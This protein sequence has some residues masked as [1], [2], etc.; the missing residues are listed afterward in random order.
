[1]W[2]N[3]VR[4]KKRP[5]GRN[6][7]TATVIKHIFIINPAAGKGVESKPLCDKIRDA[8]AVAGED[9]LIYKTTGRGDAIGFVKSQIKSKPQNETYRFYACG[10]DGTLSEVVSGAANQN[11]ADAPGP[12][13]GVEVGCIPIGTGNDFVRN[14]E[15][16]EFFSD[17][18]KQILADAA[19]IDCYS[20]GEGRC[21]VNMINIGFDCEVAARTGEYKKKLFMPKKLAYIAGIIAEFRKN[22]GKHI[23]VITEDG[24]VFDKE[25]QLVSAAN[26]GFCGGGFHSAP[27]SSLN[28][29][30]L[31]ISL[32]DKVSRRTFLG[33][34]G[35]YKKGTHLETSVGKRVV[36]YSQSKRVSFEFPEPTNVCVDGEIVK[37]ER[38]DVSVLRGAISFVIP[39]GCRLK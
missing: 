22:L 4:R 9:F 19:V 15:N 17:I 28:D 24:A 16:S 35:S 20:C 31:D 7:R 30:L 38:I 18:T 8:C 29:G 13:P 6:E 11:V 27:R 1:M 12:I 26:G 5:I 23:K 34:V 37:L 3:S 14:F 21:G 10:G 2:Y 25:F 33:L 39:V 32:I 36:K